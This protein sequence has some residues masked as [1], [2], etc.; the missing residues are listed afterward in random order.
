[1]ESEFGPDE[2]EW[3]VKHLK[4]LGFGFRISGLKPRDSTEG[5]GDLVRTEEVTDET[6]SLLNL[7][8]G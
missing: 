8:Q 3:Y 4:P 5:L 1:M 6:A 7:T 2:L